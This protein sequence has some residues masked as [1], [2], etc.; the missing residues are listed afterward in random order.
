V[1][2]PPRL[3]DEGASPAE[4]A[5]LE[6]GTSYRSSAATHAKTL[7][8]VGLA[9]TAAISASAS[10]TLSNFGWSKWLTTLSVMG[11]SAVVPVGYYV[12]KDSP[13]E[14]AVVQTAPQRA[15]PLAPL[16][17]QAPEAPPPSVPVPNVAPVTPKAVA[18]VAPQALQKSATLTQEIE[19]VDRVRSALGRGDIR[20][21][22]MALD[23][24]SRTYPRGRLSLE[25]EVLR[26]DALARSGQ[27]ESAKR[28]AEAFLRNN[29]KSALSSRVRRIVG[30]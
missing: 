27:V 2:E 30:S 25:A 20:G 3:I 7:A 8:A 9:G 14:A 5:L 6:A 13:P 11:A 15:I 28:R 1:S 24:Y 19:A 16:T 21:A 10:A 18:R 4:R 23:A 29:P 22:F 12:L 26:I 17:A